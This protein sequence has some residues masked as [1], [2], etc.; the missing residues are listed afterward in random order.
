M[1]ASVVAF[2]ILLIGLPISANAGEAFAWT[3][4][5]QLVSP[6]NMVLE[7]HGDGLRLKVPDSGERCFYS[8]DAGERRLVEYGQIITLSP[9]STLRLAAKHWQASILVIKVNQMPVLMIS[10][11]LDERSMGGALNSSKAAARLMKNG[12]LVDI[13]RGTSEGMHPG[14]FTE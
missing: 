6:L 1:K 11:K 2:L 14:F 9:E 12:K 3:S 4:A 8:I 10:K 13:D 5:G 7:P